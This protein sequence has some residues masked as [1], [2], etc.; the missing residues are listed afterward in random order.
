MKDIKQLWK[1]LLDPTPEQESSN[2]IT[3]LTR[4]LF[5]LGINVSAVTI[6]LGIQYGFKNFGLID[7]DIFP[8]IGKTNF[9]E[10]LALLLILIFIIPIIEEFA[11]RLHLVPQKQNIRISVIIL[12]VYLTAQLAYTSKSTFVISIISSLGVVLLIGYIVFHKRINDGIKQVWKN[13]FRSVFYITA[14]VF[15]CIHIMN[16]KLSVNNLIFAPIIVAPQIILGL[17]AG[18]LRV[19]SG[20]KWGLLLHIVHNVV[21]IGI[22]L[23]LMNPN[24]FNLN[25]NAFIIEYPS[26]SNP[27]KDYSLTI[28]EG[29]ESAFNTY[30]I[31]PDEISIENAKM[32][33]IFILLANANHAKV[34][35]ESQAIENKI[36]NLRFINKSWEKSNL[37][38]NRHFIIEELF[39]KYNLKAKLYIIPEGYWLLTQRVDLN[40]SLP[41]AL[42]PGQ[43]EE[44]KELITMQD[45]TVKE[46]VIKIETLY[47]LNCVAL[48]HNRNKFN[49]KMPKND[50]VAL[51]K[52]LLEKYDFEFHKMK[53][54]TDCFYI[55]SRNDE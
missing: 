39:K 47:S 54:R 37:R 14:L 21:F 33:A 9:F 16:H 36:I 49:F 4:F 20:F 31:I 23:Y 28:D 3:K 55:S 15:G 38:N 51:Q 41:K 17:N 8:V 43:N 29:K 35:F 19:K 32:K 13:K 2:F 26:T 1:Y 6:V 44:N 52:I 42:I 10:L 40:H 34:I 45:A 18:Y 48:I 11:F 46:L 22:F 25:K 30:K 12:I 27:S 24:L 7:V 53:T 50:A 5:V